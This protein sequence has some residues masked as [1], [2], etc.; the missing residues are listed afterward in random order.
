V[1]LS[2]FLGFS[3][4]HSS[5]VGLIR[6]LWTNY[7]TPQFHVVYDQPFFMVAGGVQQCSLQQLDPNNFQIYLKG[8]W[9]T[10][11]RVHALADWDPQLDG[12]LPD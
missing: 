9:A 5:S 1:C 10:D 6:N 12:P 2:Q 11:D 7:V 4:N 3:R 8:K